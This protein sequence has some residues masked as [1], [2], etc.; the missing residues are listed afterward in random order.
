MPSFFGGESIGDV[1]DFLMP[2]SHKYFNNIK[3]C[4]HTFDLQLLKPFLCCAHN[5]LLFL[6]VHGFFRGSVLEA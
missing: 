6:P 3:T 4:G 1:A 2:L 5:A